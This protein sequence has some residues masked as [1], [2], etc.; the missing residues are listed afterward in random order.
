MIEVDVD[1]VHIRTTDKKIDKTPRG[2]FIKEQTVRC[3]YVQR[4]FRAIIPDI[5][6]IHFQAILVTNMR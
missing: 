4:I 2:I 1:K 3:R 6:Y 5:P